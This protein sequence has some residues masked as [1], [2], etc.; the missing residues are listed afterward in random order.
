M[1]VA[2]FLVEHLRQILDSQERRRRAIDRPEPSEVGGDRPRQLACALVEVAAAD[3]VV[4]ELVQRRLLF[5][6]D[7][8]GERAAV[9]EHAAR[10]LGAEHRQEARDR[11]EASVVLA[12]AAS[13]DGAHEADGVRVARVVEHQLHRPLL[14]ETARVEDADALAHLRDHAEVVADEERR[15]V[16]LVLQVGDQV[17]HLRLDRRVEAGRRLVEDQERRVLGER[18]RDQDALLHPA[19]ELVR[20]AGHHRLGIGDLHLRER[21]VSPAR[22]ASA[23]EEPLTRNTSATC[24]PTRID[25]FRAVP[26]FW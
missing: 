23:F 15:G 1:D 26:G 24:C 4:R 22:A 18:H 25:G 10:R 19:R 17:E 20:I 9:G 5:A 3:P 13:R 6:A 11:V 7:L 16:E 2:T 8:L 21:L 12:H 14:D